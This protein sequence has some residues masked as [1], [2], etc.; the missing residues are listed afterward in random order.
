MRDFRP[1]LWFGDCLEVMKRIPDHS[2][3]MILADLPYGSTA[4]KWDVVIPVEP[5][6]E[7][8]NRV[9]KPHRAIVLTAREPFTSVLVSSNIRHYKHKWVWNKKQSGSFQNAKFMPLQIEEDVLVFSS[10]GK[11]VYYP[12]MRK[13]KMRK[14]GGA[15]EKSRV[16]GKGLRDGYENFSDQY[17]P[18]N[19][20]EMAN[21]RKGKLHPTEKPVALM[22]YLIR[23]YTR[24]G[25]MVLDNSMGSGTTGVACRNTERTFIGIDNDKR[26]YDMAVKRIL[27]GTD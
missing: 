22:E 8:Y 1:K 5:L 19:I 15:R 21:P 10:G 11:V 9:I 26:F 16:V 7:A 20:I 14:R 2:V 6:W 27:G 24:E 17:F 3:D 4:C 18:V 23:T 25:E 12:I 13:G